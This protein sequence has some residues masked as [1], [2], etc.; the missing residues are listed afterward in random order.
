MQS[1]KFRQNVR[2]S[3]VVLGNMKNV[4]K[5]PNKDKKSGANYLS[6]LKARNSLK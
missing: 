5:L 1:L 2:Q 3:T 6:N 4:M